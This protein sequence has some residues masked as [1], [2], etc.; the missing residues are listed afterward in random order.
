MEK[1]LTIS[2]AAYNAELD[3][4]RCLDSFISTNVLEE[5]EL[6]VVNDGSKDNTLNVAKQYE[7]KYPGIIKVI[8][9]KNGGHVL[10]DGVLYLKHMQSSL[11][12]QNSRELLQVAQQVRNLFIM[13]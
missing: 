11:I 3:I 2:I 13:D 9:K 10:M 8:D 7:K 12:L 6:I 1:I 4:K 5:L